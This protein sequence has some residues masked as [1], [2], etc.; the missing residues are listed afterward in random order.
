MTMFDR[1]FQIARIAGV[2]APGIPHHVTQRGN[3]R[4]RTF[5]HDE[6]LNPVRAGMIKKPE[7]WRWSSAG[8]HAKAKRTFLSTPSH[9]ITLGK[10]FIRRRSGIGNGS[11]Q[12]A[13]VNRQ[14]N[15]R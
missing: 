4:R 13:C 10:F 14:A 2:V 7:T 11:F 15:G 1:H 8:A 12:K 3:R 5:F 6:E 9:K